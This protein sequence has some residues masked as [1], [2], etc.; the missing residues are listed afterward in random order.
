[1]LNSS[2]LF[3]NFFFLYVIVVT[4]C[5]KIIG[6]QMSFRKINVRQVSLTCSELG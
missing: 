2:T 4:I 6:L 5:L 1:M 3:N